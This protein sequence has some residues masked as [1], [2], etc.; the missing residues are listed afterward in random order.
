MAMKIIDQGPL[1][2][3]LQL[4]QLGRAAAPALLPRPRRQAAMTKMPK[5]ARPQSLSQRSAA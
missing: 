2:R 1:E 3:P 5:Q 4:L